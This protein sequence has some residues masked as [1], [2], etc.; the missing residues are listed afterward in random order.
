MERFNEILLFPLFI[1]IFFYSLSCFFI[2]PSLTEV[3]FG[4]IK[5]PVHTREKQQKR[6]RNICLLC[7]VCGCFFLLLIYFANKRGIHWHGE[8]A[9]KW[10]K[11]GPN[12]IQIPNSVFDYKIQLRNH[13]CWFVTITA[14]QTV[15]Q[16]VCDHQEE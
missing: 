14:A 1:F 9:Q 7:F 6:K 12:Q 4:F 16:I 13:S 8:G 10:G 5:A 2:F 15:Q 3:L 11:G